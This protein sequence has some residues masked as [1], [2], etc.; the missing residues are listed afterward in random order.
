[1]PFGG[2]AGTLLIDQDTA[3]KTIPPSKKSDS[4]NLTEIADRLRELREH[5]TALLGE[6][7]LATR[8]PAP[9]RNGYVRRRND[10]AAFR[11]LPR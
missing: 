11:F 9:D 10:K 7:P 4:G 3:M 5:A 8:R 6:A 2:R 1:M